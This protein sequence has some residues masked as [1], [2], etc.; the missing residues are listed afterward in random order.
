MK[1]IHEII[2]ATVKGLKPWEK[3]ALE[4]LQGTQNNWVTIDGENREYT[5]WEKKVMAR[6]SKSKIEFEKKFRTFPLQIDDS[7][8]SYTPDF[9]LDFAYKNRRRVIVEVHE[10]LT[11]FDIKKYST[12][13]S[14]YGRIYFLIMVVSDGQLRKWNEIDNG[15]QILY[16][17]IWTLNAIEDMIQQLERLR[18]VSKKQY[19]NEEATCPKCGKFAQGKF[20]IE[21]LFGYRG[22]RVQSYCKVC[23]NRK[24]VDDKIIP[25][26]KQ[27]P[28]RVYCPGCGKNFMEKERGELYCQSC[29]EIYHSKR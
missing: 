6:L 26:I 10:D 25:E 18:E 22:E 12:F 21:E 14:I 9:V 7:S 5:T 19:E 2:K 11:D 20:E 17:D 15:N 13:M 29:I 16:H 3:K 24:N 27:N 4:E 8:V 1:D 23:R 28:K